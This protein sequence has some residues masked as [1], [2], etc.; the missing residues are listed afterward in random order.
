METRTSSLVREEGAA[1][2][3]SRQGSET[4]KDARLDSLFTAS[5]QASVYHQGEGVTEQTLR[6]LVFD[7]SMPADSLTRL[8]PLKAVVE[9]AVRASRRD[10]TSYKGSAESSTQ[11]AS[12][13]S[14]SMGTVVLDETVIT[15]A[16]M[17]KTDTEG[18]E[19]SIVR[20]RSPTIAWWK[21][22]PILLMAAGGV[23]AMRRLIR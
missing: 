6:V 19:E 23:Y 22:L 17:G 8:P 7:T 10:S 9:Q 1:L 3:H 4:H 16:R 15:A 5:S 14:E 2:Q 20:T 21:V 13:T 11:K 18:V 12:S